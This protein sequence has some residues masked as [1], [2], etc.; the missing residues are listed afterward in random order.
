MALIG[1]HNARALCR[2]LEYLRTCFAA[3]SVMYHCKS[4][5]LF[6]EPEVFL[7]VPN[8]EDEMRAERFDDMAVKVDGVIQG[9]KRIGSFLEATIEND[10]AHRADVGM[11]RWDDEYQDS[12]RI[13]RDKTLS[14][15]ETDSSSSG[16]SATVPNKRP[17]S[18]SPSPPSPVD[19]SA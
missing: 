6:S 5:G 4:Y 1:T 18:F 15:K 8:V 14:P 13:R 7:M 17:L 19:S 2:R 9:L 3:Q 11:E 16:S 12:K 10:R